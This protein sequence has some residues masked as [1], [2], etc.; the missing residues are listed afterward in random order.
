MVMDAQVELDQARSDRGRVE[1]MRTY[2]IDASSILAN[3]GGAADDSTGGGGGAAEATP[4]SAS[5]PRF[6]PGGGGS[7]GSGSL[8]A[9]SGSGLAPA[10]SG[11]S[12]VEVAGLHSQLERAR[13]Q[14]GK[15]SLLV[16]EIEA[17][18]VEK[19]VQFVNAVDQ[20]N[21]LD[22]DNRQLRA[23]MQHLMRAVEELTAR[24]AQM[25]AELTRMQRVKR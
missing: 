6:S 10:V 15:L 13:R 23:N 9:R 1:F 18:Y 5:S 2:N 8:S 4:S 12:A 16:A 7:S 11:A 25:Q 14:C 24:N 20:L 17:K 21:A 22:G 19:Q 3:S